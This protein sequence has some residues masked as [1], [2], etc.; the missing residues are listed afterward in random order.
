MNDI[1]L[2]YRASRLDGAGFMG[3][4]VDAIDRIISVCDEESMRR[5]RVHANTVLGYRKHRKMVT[6][7]VLKH[8]QYAKRFLARC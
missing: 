5:E 2:A 7:S 1:A 4:E 8:N 6:Y 3:N